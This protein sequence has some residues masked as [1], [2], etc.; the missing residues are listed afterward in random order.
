MNILERIREQYKN[1]IE[2]SKRRIN[3]TF[4]F[5]EPDRVP[6]KISTGG[7][8]YAHMFGYDIKDYYEDLEVQIDV[9]VRSITWRFENL[10]DDNYSTDI[11][12]DIGPLAEGLYFDCPI[13]RPSGTSPRIVPILETPEDILKFKVPEPEESEGLK[14]LDRKFAEFK[15]IARKKY[16]IKIESPGPRLQIHPPLSAACALMEPDKVYLLMASEPEIARIFFEKMFLAFCKLVDYYDRRYQTKTTSIHLANDNTCFIS[17]K[18]YREQVLEFDKAIYERYGT[19][20][21]GLHTDGPSDH[22]FKTFAE[23]LKLNYMDIGG[24]SSIERAVEDLKGKVVIFGG[25][26]NKDFYDG[27]TENAKEKIRRTL[28]LA[29]L[30]GGYICG[31]GGETYVGVSPAVLIEFVKYVKEAGRYPLYL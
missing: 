30:G 19:T 3:T 11:W 17:N 18:M 24:W 25:L 29:S 14:W 5:K 10:K 16:E 22:N 13:V 6:I 27:F 1:E 8:Y 15:E 7:S 9:Q 2:S 28:K 4:A 23:D 31:I 12:L 20:Y 26:N 21:R